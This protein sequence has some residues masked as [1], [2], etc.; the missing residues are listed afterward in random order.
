M[1][2]MYYIYEVSMP[3]LLIESTNSVTKPTTMLRSSSQLSVFQ[4]SNA[5]TGSNP[6]WTNFVFHSSDTGEDYPHLYRY[7]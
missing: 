1:F 5:C 2:V 4:V 6:A 7:L 3:S